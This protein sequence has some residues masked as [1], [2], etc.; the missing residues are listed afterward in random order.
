MSKPFP[1]VPPE[2]ARP[3]DRSRLTFT[4]TV[5]GQAG[6]RA[7]ASPH[8]NVEPP[9]RRCSVRP[10]LARALA[11]ALLLGLALPAFADNT[12]DEAD[13]AFRL[14]NEA[15][16]KRKYDDA[17]A[18]YFLSNRLVPNKNVLY[19]IARC[20]E[21]LKSYDEAY[22]YYFDL[23]TAKDLA[24]ED[25]KDV[26][27]A[28]ERLAP[29]VALISVTTETPGAEVY[30]D[31]E[32]LGSRGRAPQVLAIN[33]GTHK[34]K[35]KLA[36]R[37]DAET[38]VRVA[39]GAEK[40]VKLELTPV[41]GTV[42]IS[43]SPEGATVRE[44]EDGPELGRLPAKLTF[45]P[46]QRLFLISAPGYTSTQLLVT[47]RA[48]ETLSSRASL[49]PLPAPTGKVIVTANRENA[50][51][52]VDGKESGFT[53]T[54]LVLP[55]GKHEVEVSLKEFRTVS[56]SIEVKQDA[57]L[58][59]AAELRYAAP[60]VRAASKAL[61]D[62]DDAPASITVITREEIQAMGWQTLADALAAVR[63]VQLHQ[64]RIY[65]YLGVRGF[66]PPGDLNTRVLILWDGHYIND[67]WAGQG[68]AERSLEVDMAEIERIEIVRGPGSALYG[69]GAFFAVINVVPRDVVGEGKHV[70][71]VGGAGGQW[72]GKGRVTASVGNDGPTALVTAAGFTAAGDPVTDRGPRGVVNGSDGVTALSA[73]VRVRAGGFTFHGRFNHRPKQIPVAPYDT[74][75]G[76]PGTSFTDT[77]GFAELRWEKDWER[78][79]ISIRGYYDL[80]RYEGSY[81]YETD[82]HPAGISV[83][84]DLGGADWGGG[85]ARARI[86][87][88][89]GNVL[90]IGLEGQY[91]SIRQADSA[92]GPLTP[93]GFTRVLLSAYL[94]DEWR[95][96][97]RLSVTA[98][99]RVDK[100]LDLA[101]TPITPRLGLVARLYDG[102]VTKLV[103]GS[104]FRAPNIYETYQNDGF[105][106]Q[107][108]VRGQLAPETLYTVELEHGHDVNEELRITI[109]GFFNVIDKLVILDLDTATMPFECGDPADPVPC[110]V[111]T[112]S[113][114]LIFAAGGEAGFRWQPSRFL[115][116]DGQYSFVRL[117]GATNDLYTLT[118]QHLVAMKTVVPLLENYVRVSAQAT[119]ASARSGTNQGET[120]VLNFGFSGSFSHFRYFAG[121]QNLLDSRTPVP[122][123][124]A[125]QFPPVPIY[126]RTFWVE[127]ALSL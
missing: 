53:P 68:F 81:I 35:V 62:A 64:D 25:A 111:N 98:G 54:V 40:K 1:A 76:A 13:V 93:R 10:T 87:L 70:E 63:G 122:V 114:N 79:S 67:I 22:R 90:S 113:R 104:A 30:I 23:S 61:T 46:G 103:A 51:V 85:E 6:G 31:R 80:T 110:Q 127:L 38:T 109:G 27:A 74:L 57:D 108:P 44:T 24:P 101:A 105:I 73:G 32:D 115:F 116:V 28:L 69:T 45:P 21:A 126:G 83:Q 118:S 82:E 124:T 11:Y 18:A 123:P 112:N 43:G 4:V 52:R 26:Q 56:Q 20:Y 72:G 9:P 15:Y 58:K 99:V 84:R 48:D 120:F 42:E 119:Y 75:V 71:L 95:I 7:G 12:A 60:K 100:Y 41:V 92:E 88:F 29:K 117:I 107:R 5:T 17:L 34:V 96:T 3:R 37:H 50:L 66:S 91:Q 49:T 14:G 106:S 102:G 8:P 65:S 33:P 97:R 36:G 16:S 39:K 77:R 19:N 86:K 125:G 59:I 2:P 78:L 121:V 89:E 94:L 47:V 55:V